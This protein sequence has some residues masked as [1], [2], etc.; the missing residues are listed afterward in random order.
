M[1]I[2]QKFQSRGV[3]FR[4]KRNE[5]LYLKNAGINDEVIED[6]RKCKQEILKALD[7]EKEQWILLRDTENN[8]HIKEWI[9]NII[10]GRY[11]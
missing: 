3:R 4:K 10:K 5:L 2:I 8:P 7:E 6:I 1:T 9:N 11:E